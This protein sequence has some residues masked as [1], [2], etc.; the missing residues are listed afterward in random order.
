MRLKDEQR[1]PLALLFEMLFHRQSVTSQVW[2]NAGATEANPVDA[3]LAAQIV[4]R[5]IVWLRTF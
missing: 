3:T 2:L 5:A 1:W 4:P